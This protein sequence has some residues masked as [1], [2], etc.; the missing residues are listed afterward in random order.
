[1]HPFPNLNDARS[2]KGHVGIDLEGWLES[3][4][5]RLVVADGDKDR[6]HAGKRAEVAQLE[7]QGAF[8]VAQEGFVFSHQIVN[9]GAL[10]SPFGKVWVDLYYL[11][12]VF[13]AP[14]KL[15]RDMT[16]IPLVISFF[17]VSPAS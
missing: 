12:K 15:R 10:V 14:L 5:G 8:Y 3:F 4:E 1:M 9:R 13:N 2:G 11:S 17:N 7:G 6:S 16:S